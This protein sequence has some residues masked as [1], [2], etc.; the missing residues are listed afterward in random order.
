MLAGERG[1][2]AQEAAGVERSAS[3]RRNQLGR[4]L[5]QSDVPVTE[6]NGLS[7]RLARQ[8]SMRTGPD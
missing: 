8:R 3:F 2:V 1:G 7:I 5:S 4:S 6:K